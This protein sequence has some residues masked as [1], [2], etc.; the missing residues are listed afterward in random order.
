MA[1]YPVEAAVTPKIVL[2]PPLGSCD[3]S[4]VGAAFSDA[5]RFTLDLTVTS[6]LSVPTF[7]LSA[8]A[9]VVVTDV[10]G[11]DAVWVFETNQFSI[12]EVVQ[13]AL[14]P[15]QS[16]L[17]GAPFTGSATL[18]FSSSVFT[19]TANGTLQQIPTLAPSDGALGMRVE[20]TLIVLGQPVLIKRYNASMN[21]NVLPLPVTPPFVR[22]GYEM[23]EFSVING[24]LT[25]PG[26]SFPF[27]T[28]RATGNISLQ[29][30]GYSLFW[31]LNFTV[32]PFQNVLGEA[33][34][35]ANLQTTTG[36]GVNFYGKVNRATLN[37]S[38]TGFA[39]AFNSGDLV[40]PNYVESVTG[41]IA[42]ITGDNTR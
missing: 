26:F 30:D 37:V 36:F 7:G 34:Y 15:L 35:P 14:N 19:V 4:F 18:T 31:P 27:G 1:N 11:G 5:T 38:F 16:T 22:F 33:I 20:Y 21:I 29:G 13:V 9:R 8:I 28:T 17:G 2:I 40:I 12:Q 42:I 39:T 6:G 41:N 25:I 32:D 23:Q 24:S 10:H 3:T